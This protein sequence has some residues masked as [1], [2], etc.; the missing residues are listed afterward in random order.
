MSAP[1]ESDKVRRKLLTTLDAV[2][3]ELTRLRAG[4]PAVASERELLVVIDGLEKMLSGLTE[5]QRL[6]APGLRH[7]VI[8]TWPR[9]SAAGERV[10]EAEYAHERLK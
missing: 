10:L 1:E 2:R 7:I 6:P 3:Q 5:A 9:S 8:G 4:Q